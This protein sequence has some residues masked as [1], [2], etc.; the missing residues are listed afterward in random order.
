MILDL[1]IVVILVLSFISG[2]R[3]GFVAEFLNLVGFI[4][5]LALAWR[6]NSAISD[7]I[8]TQFNLTGHHQLVY[9]VSFL[10][11][12]YVS[13]AISNVIKTSN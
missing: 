7:W 8:V 1:I 2:Y 12:L 10:V 11:Y 9:W 6:Y 5:A 4:F 13:L 3:R